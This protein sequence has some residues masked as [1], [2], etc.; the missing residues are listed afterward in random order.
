MSHFSVKCLKK[1]V[2][3]FP[4]MH[5]FSISRPSLAR[6]PDGHEDRLQMTKHST[7]KLGHL[8]KWNRKLRIVFVIETRWSDT[9]SLATFVPLKGQN[10]LVRAP[11]CMCVCMYVYVCVWVRALWLMPPSSHLIILVVRAC[12]VSPLPPF[13]HPVLLTS[14]NPLPPPHFS[15][16]TE[17]P[18]F[19]KLLLWK[20]RQ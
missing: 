10:R 12:D 19:T 14:L 15:V 1:S 13:N 17:R 16:W 9:F 5:D 4:S 2:R 18:I 11:L 3:K 8:R 20:S 6:N 7:R